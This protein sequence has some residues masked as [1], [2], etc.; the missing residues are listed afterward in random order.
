MPG[1]YLEYINNWIAYQGNDVSWI[2]SAHGCGTLAV[3]QPIE[4]NKKTTS[5]FSIF[6]QWTWPKYCML[7]CARPCSAPLAGVLIEVSP[8]RDTRE[9]TAVERKTAG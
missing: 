9:E 8:L 2:R 1:I 5:S 4:N 3:P 7:P 6:F